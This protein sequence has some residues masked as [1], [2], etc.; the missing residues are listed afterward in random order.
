MIDKILWLAPW[1][2]AGLMVTVL[3][4]QRRWHRSVLDL[5]KAHQRQ[6]DA[7]KEQLKGVVPVT[8]GPAGLTLEPGQCGS[9]EIELPPE[10]A[11]LV[12]KGGKLTYQ[13]GETIA[14]GGGRFHRDIYMAVDGVPQGHVRVAWEGAGADVRMKD[15]I[16]T[17]PRTKPL[18]N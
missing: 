12:A 14:D 9:T 7:L 2:T 16:S 5:F 13:E 17:K 15:V 8:I 1:I 4:L 10:V 18:V 11:E 3:V 6:I